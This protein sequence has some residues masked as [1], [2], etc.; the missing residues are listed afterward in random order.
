MRLTIIF[1]FYFLFFSTDIYSQKESYSWYFGANAAITFDTPDGEP[2]ALNNSQVNTLEGVSSISDS[3]GKLMFY[4]DGVRVWNSQHKV[5]NPDTAMHGH[6][7]ST[8]SALIVKK[9]GCK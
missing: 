4:T 1:I 8:Q 3:T 6:F 7:S 2:I 9:P 5:M